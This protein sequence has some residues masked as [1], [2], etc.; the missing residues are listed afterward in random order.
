MQI[1]SSIYQIW[2]G[3]RNNINNENI[4][5]ILGVMERFIQKEDVLMNEFEKLIQKQ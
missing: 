3:T 1:F 4:K 2:E 5:H